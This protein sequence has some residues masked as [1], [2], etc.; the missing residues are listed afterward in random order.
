MRRRDACRRSPLTR[1]ACLA[2]A[3]LPLIAACAAPSSPT[4]ASRRTTATSSAAAASNPKAPEALGSVY[5]QA[6]AGGLSPRVA[7]QRSLVY[8]PNHSSGTI[9]VID[10]HSL[11]VIDTFPAGRGPQHVVPSWDLSTL[12]V[13]DDEGGDE[14]TPIDPRTGRRR[15]PNVPVADPYNMYFTPDGASAIV[16][17]EAQQRLDL[18]DP[19]TMR[20]QASIPV[21]CPGIN[22]AD[23][24]ADLSYALFSCEF[25][26]QLVQVDLRNR[27][28]LGYLKLPGEPAA[29]AQDVRLA[30][31][32]DVFYVADMA[33]GGLHVIDARGGLREVGFLPTG[34][35]THG[36]L[37]SR[38]GRLL[39]VSNRGGPS[40]AGSVS[41]IDPAAR[42]V[43]ATWSIPGGG[44]PDM[45]GVSADGRQLWL[46][47]RRSD[48]VYV[49]DTSTGRLL[50]KVPVG[51][52]PH[53]LAV[54]P[55]PG[56]F[57]LGHTGLMR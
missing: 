45:G 56:R 51:R 33:R 53:G 5:A 14:L 48:V 18:R 8:V 57:S 12:W 41:V 1:G 35:E 34:P 20:L 3:A 27:R 37:P 13:N 28:V 15:G 46:S 47:G 19:R 4:R 25:S 32:G 55:Q 9:S 50:A 49:L 52:E 42:R 22:H 11:R 38:D 24:S 16:V 29:M 7:G 17:A 30:P 40:A 6:A 31:A 2:T 54:W 36:I 10:P 44:T 26:S 23:F 43:I 39:Y 21:A